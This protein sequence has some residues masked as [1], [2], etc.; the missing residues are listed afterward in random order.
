VIRNAWDQLFTRHMHQLRETNQVADLEKGLGQYLVYN[1]GTWPQSHPS[2]SPGDLLQET[3][4]LCLVSSLYNSPRHYD[5]APGPSE[6]TSQTSPCH[7][8]SRHAAL[9]HQRRLSSNFDDSSRP[10]LQRQ[11]HAPERL[12]YLAHLDVGH[13][14]WRSENPEQ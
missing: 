10:Y 13:F 5:P 3:I 8:S 2:S 9:L 4:L 11:A 1:I 7:L 12:L 6:Q 14:S